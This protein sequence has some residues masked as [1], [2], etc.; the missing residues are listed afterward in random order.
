MSRIW[1]VPGVCSAS[2]PPCPAWTSFATGVAPQS[3]ILPSGRSPDCVT[4][5]HP[6]GDPAPNEVPGPMS[7]KWAP[8]SGHRHR[9]HGN[10]VLGVPGFLPHCL[11]PFAPPLVHQLEPKSPI[12]CSSLLLIQPARYIPSFQSHL[13][14]S[15][16]EDTSFLARAAWW[17]AG[18]FLPFARNITKTP[19]G[20]IPSHFPAVFWMRINPKL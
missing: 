6:R 5:W 3:A 7:R 15:R 2:P 16:T 13:F 12:D 17:S 1:S 11:A 10:R 8:R 18:T 19:G 9:N 14:G 4:R 20:K